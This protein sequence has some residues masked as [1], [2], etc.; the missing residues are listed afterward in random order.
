VAVVVVVVVHLQ[1]EKP[2]VMAVQE[3]LLLDIK[4]KLWQL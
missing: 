1:V 4:D 3:L 2:L